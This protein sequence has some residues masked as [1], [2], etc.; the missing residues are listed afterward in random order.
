[1]DM[2]LVEVYHSG[3]NATSQRPSCRR[4]GSRPPTTRSGSFPFLG[5]NSIS[6]WPA[7]CVLLVGETSRA[8][9]HYGCAQFGVVSGEE[10][11]ITCY[12]STE[13]ASA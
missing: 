2:L 6:G 5:L 4:C 13:I 12:R 1:M 11:P 10:F 8:Q 9:S 3:L 7:P